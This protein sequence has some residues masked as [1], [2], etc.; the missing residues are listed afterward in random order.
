[1]YIDLQGCTV[2]VDN[3]KF[4]ICPTNAHT[5]YSKIVELLKTLYTLKSVL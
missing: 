1:M 5:N 3:I 4:F 2:H